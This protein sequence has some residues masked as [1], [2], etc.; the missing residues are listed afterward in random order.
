[1]KN[2]KFE[3]YAFAYCQKLSK[4]KIVAS[5]NLKVEYCCFL[6]A[7]NLMDV[8]L[9]GGDLFISFDVFKNCS[10]LYWVSFESTYNYF[11]S[12]ETFRSC[13]C[14]IDTSRLKKVNKW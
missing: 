13:I 4:F 1:M 2:A 10:S 3:N 12:E 14:R 8:K 9:A 7:K 6:N 11:I 5:E